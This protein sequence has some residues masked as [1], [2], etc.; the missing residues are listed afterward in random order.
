MKRKVFIKILSVIIITFTFLSLS[1]CTGYDKVSVGNIN[2]GYSKSRK[3]C[4]VSRIYYTLG[5]DTNMIIPD[6]YNGYEITKLG[7]Y[8]GRGVPDPFM[9]EISN[10]TW[11]HE[12]SLKNGDYGNNAIVT[13]IVFTITLP[14]YLKEIQNTNCDTIF[15]CSSNDSGQ[16]VYQIYRPVYY[17]IISASNSYFYTENGKLYKKDTD[18]LITGFIYDAFVA[19]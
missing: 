11:G 19:P 5:E 17:F 4:Y 12:K 7:G 9:I 16:T 6:T 8:F 10:M 15:Y 3:N 13:D 2:L 1:A 18:E 14:N